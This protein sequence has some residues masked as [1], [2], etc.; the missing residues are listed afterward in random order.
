MPKNLKGGNKAK[1]QKNS[2]PNTK[3]K[4]TYLPSNSAN[5]HV[6][7]VNKKY[8]FQQYDVTIVSDNGHKNETTNAKAHGGKKN[9]KIENGQYVLLEYSEL[10]SGTFYITDAYQAQDVEILKQQGFIPVG[11]DKMDTDEI[12]FGS[13]DDKDI[14]VI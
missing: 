4:P 7:V 11:N 1:K 9:I 3:I 12:V 2:I 10:N 6:G 13:M 8:G 14:S 5:E